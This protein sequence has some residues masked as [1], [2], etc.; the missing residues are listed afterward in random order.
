MDGIGFWVMVLAVAY[1][2]RIYS[3]KAAGWGWL[4]IISASFAVT[5]VGFFLF[6]FILSL[7]RR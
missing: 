2:W 6:A 5:L 3:P 4:R 1:I 7:L